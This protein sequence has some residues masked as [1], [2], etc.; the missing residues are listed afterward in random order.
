M[1]NILLNQQI[2]LIIY[3]NF[4]RTIKI[5]SQFW[6]KC[7]TIY[8]KEDICDMTK[9]EKY[10]II[11]CN[12]NAIIDTEHLE[13]INLNFPIV[14]LISPPTSSQILNKTLE[15]TEKVYNSK[16]IKQ[17]IIYC[18]HT[19]ENTICQRISKKISQ[20][21]KINDYDLININ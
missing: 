14:T 15:Y 6:D 20:A 2:K 10:N 17:N 4:D 12:M 16:Y 18:Y 19:V 11:I 1:C 3:V 5:L 8:K 13:K 21:L 9:L 7:I